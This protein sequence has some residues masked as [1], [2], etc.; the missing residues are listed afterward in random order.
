MTPPIPLVG[1]PLQRAH[2]F[3]LIEAMI[4]VAII[5]ILSAIAYPS[6]AEHVRRGRRS[7]AQTV[8]LEAAQY[9]Q[10][11]YAANNSFKDATLTDNLKKSPRDGTA[12]YDIEVSADTRTYTLTAK[13]TGSMSGDTCGSLTLKDT[14]ARGVGSGATVAH[15]WR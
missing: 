5:C 9:M 3:T 8:L 15:C 7:D 2:G 10:R 4:V 6:Y 1:S 11:Y 14:G 13:P 12:A